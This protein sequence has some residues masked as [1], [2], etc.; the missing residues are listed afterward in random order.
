MIAPIVMAVFVASAQATGQ[1]GATQQPPAAE[2][3][4]TAE[5]P[6]PPAGVS[7]PGGDVKLP[8]L[9]KDVKPHYRSDAMRARIEGVVKMEA[10]VQTDG[11]VGEV[12]VTRSLDREFGLDDEAVNSLK[13]WQFAAGTKDGVAVPVLVEV[14]MSFAM[15][16]NKK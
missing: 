4:P 14:E 13:K 6:W 5:T 9:I 15:R 3:Q 7:R 16:S 11:T 2:A 1:A 12:R 10:V 8:R